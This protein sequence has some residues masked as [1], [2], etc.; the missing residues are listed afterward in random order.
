[1]STLIYHFSIG[2]VSCGY[3]R[4]F[5]PTEKFIRLLL[6]FSVLSPLV[7]R[8]VSLIISRLLPEISLS[9]DILMTIS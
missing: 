9:L 1:M 5:L 2:T 4:S 7:S 6:C 8:R 3:F